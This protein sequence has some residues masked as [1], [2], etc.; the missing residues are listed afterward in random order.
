MDE[1]DLPEELTKLISLWDNG[2]HG[3]AF[4]ALVEK[5][6]QL[7]REVVVLRHRLQTHRHPA[8]LELRRF[9]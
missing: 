2:E 5:F 1:Q 6:A 8:P 9:T 7:Q 4:E 3:P